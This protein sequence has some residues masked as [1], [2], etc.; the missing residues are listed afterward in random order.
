[1]E[2]LPLGSPS[3]RAA[4]RE[5]CEPCRFAFL[6]AGEPE[7][8]MALEPADYFS[9]ERRAMAGGLRVAVIGRI[10]KDYAGLCRV[11]EGGVPIPLPAPRRP[12]EDETE[13]GIA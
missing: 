2:D 3:Y 9:L 13:R 4:E 1:V 8:L 12:A 11:S 7:L 6:E 10:V 5:Q